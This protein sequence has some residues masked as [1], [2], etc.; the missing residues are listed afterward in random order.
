M[1]T[2]SNSK[3]IVLVKDLAKSESPQEIYDFC[4]NNNYKIVYS[5]YY[6]L[7]E[8]KNKNS[9]CF[10]FELPSGY[11]TYRL[12]KKYSIGILSVLI[13]RDIFLDNKFNKEYNIVGDFDFFLEIS[14]K[15]KIGVIQEP[16][17]NYRLHN[18]NYSK[19]NIQNHILE[20]QNWLR[21]NKSKFEKNKYNLVNI[22]INILKL[23]FKNLLVKLFN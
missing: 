1:E 11:I 22:K 19:K 4:Q 15:F 10:N 9:I 21:K 12:L 17:A 2:N 3:V 8:I 6:I 18:S 13:D 16:L 14:M 23:K 20:L 7:N 5:N